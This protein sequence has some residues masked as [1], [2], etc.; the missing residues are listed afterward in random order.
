MSAQSATA[1]SSIHSDYAWA[2]QFP[3]IYSYI[4]YISYDPCYP[5]EY[6]FTRLFKHTHSKATMSFEWVRNSKIKHKTLYWH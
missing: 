3:N 2:I 1:N 6:E 4:S 5:F